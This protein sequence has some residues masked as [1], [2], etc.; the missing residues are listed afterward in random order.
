MDTDTDLDADVLNYRRRTYICSFNR[1]YRVVFLRETSF[2][3][4]CND[5]RVKGAKHP[6][7]KY[8]SELTTE[9]FMQVTA[10]QILFERAL[11]IE[12]AWPYL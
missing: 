8:W 11:S 9:L 7:G 10:M 5:L 1:M 6:D 4:H 12:F 2:V 3:S